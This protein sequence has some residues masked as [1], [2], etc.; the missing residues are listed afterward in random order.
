MVNIGKKNQLSVIAIVEAGALLEGESYGRILLP[1]RYLPE[2]CKTGD[3]VDVFVYWDSEDRLVA[4]TETPLA[5][6]DE[7]AWLKVVEV[8]NVGAFLDWGLP[9]DLLLP[10]SEHKYE[11]IAG[12]RVMVRLFLDDQTER[13]AATTQIDRF[14]S[15]EAEG[16]TPGQEVDLVISDQTS[17]GYKAIV[18]HSYWGILYSNEL[19]QTLNKGQRLR[20]Y[21]KKIRDDKRLDLSLYQP[22]AGQ[23][24]GIAEKIIEKLIE[25]DGV[26]MLTDK[27]PPEAIYS[28]FKVSKKVYKKAIG[29]LYKQRRIVIEARSIRLVD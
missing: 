14:L 10:Y 29:T 24:A 23:V 3:V 26:L 13:I 1:N 8:N 27:S 28:I 6:V 12:R 11:P 25:H 19:F 20:G 17:L 18:D 4:T 9:K 2:A 7:F 21:V 16:F 15:D 22:G 5:M